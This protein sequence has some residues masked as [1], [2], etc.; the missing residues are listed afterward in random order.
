MGYAFELVDLMDLTVF[1]TWIQELIRGMNPDCLLTDKPL[2]LTECIYAHDYLM[3]MMEVDTRHSGIRKEYSSG[4]AP[5]EDAL[6]KAM[7]SKQMER[8]LV[9]GL[10]SA[11]ER[12]LRA[13]NPKD[14]YMEVKEDHHH[15]D[16]VTEAVG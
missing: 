12:R 4:K 7:N 16:T 13:Q 14:K 15:Y 6:V 2:T 10:L 1:N 5:L 3:K 9:L 8:A 11:G